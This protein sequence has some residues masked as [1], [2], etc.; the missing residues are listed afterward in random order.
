MIAVL[1]ALVTI[2]TAQN[3]A[4]FDFT[5]IANVDV[6][7]NTITVTGDATIN[8]ATALATS[9][10]LL[11]EA[12]HTLTLEADVSVVTKFCGDRAFL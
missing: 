5:S 7:S 1:F 8:S 6:V 12:Q 2:A 4:T 10:D 3:V 11:V 9:L